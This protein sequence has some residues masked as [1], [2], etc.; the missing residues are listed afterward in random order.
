MLMFHHY[1][2]CLCDI[3]LSDLLELIFHLKTSLIW[4]ILGL[5]LAPIKENIWRKIIAFQPPPKM[6]WMQ[7]RSSLSFTV[8][9][10]FECTS[11]TLQRLHMGDSFHLQNHYC[12]AKSTNLLQSLWATPSGVLLQDVELSCHPKFHLKKSYIICMK[13]LTN[14]IY[15]LTAGILPD[16]SVADTMVSTPQSWPALCYFHSGTHDPLDFLLIIINIKVNILSCTYWFTTFKRNVNS[17]KIIGPERSAKIIYA[18]LH[19]FCQCILLTNIYISNKIGINYCFKKE[20][21]WCIYQY[22]VTD[23]P[24]LFSL[25]KVVAHCD[26]QCYCS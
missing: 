3:H 22:Q 4:L 25:L 20:V 5:I 7:L 17:I 14:T 21:L 10:V 23:T 6:I 12:N 16:F 24:L 8:I 11:S 18:C 19:I 13:L 26:L 1:I 15:I 2:Q 9:S